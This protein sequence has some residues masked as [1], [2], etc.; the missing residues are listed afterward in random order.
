MQL[1]QSLVPENRL[2]ADVRAVEPV[3]DVTTAR[4]DALVSEYVSI[5]E[6]YGPFNSGTGADGAHYAPADAN[7]FA[8]EG[9]VCGNCELYQPISDTEG[10]CAVV[11]G[12]LVDGQIEPNAICKLW[13][14]PEGKLKQ[15]RRDTVKSE[16]RIIGERDIRENPSV[17]SELRDGG[18]FIE[19][20]IAPMTTEVR[21]NS[22]GSWTLVGHAAVFDSMSESLGNFN[23]TIQ[24]G[25][26]RKALRSPDLAVK[27]LF[28][29]DQN[30]VLG[31]TSNGTLSLREDPTGLRYEV[32]VA[33]TSYG[34][35]LRVLLERG[36]ITQSSFAFKVNKDGQ[37]WSDQEDGTL[38]RTIT[39]FSEILDVSAVTYPAYT[40]TT[41]TALPTEAVTTYS[42]NEESERGT[43]GAAAQDVSQ[44]DSLPRRADEEGAHRQRVRRLRLRDKRAA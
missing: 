6:K 14:I 1:G 4:Q 24:R 18:D 16:I 34:R 31:S 26:F 36:D 43:V 28:N 30:L 23:E 20:R 39:E 17:V 25:A 44:V 35:D 38:L 5:A 33:D 41:S 3:E 10:R 12:P 15:S 22:D 7:P 8:A 13:V 19:Q 11:Q 29:H 32:N 42:S 9:L 40:A 37:Q 2:Q 27:A 21:G